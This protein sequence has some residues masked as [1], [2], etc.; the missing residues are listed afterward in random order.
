VATL[1][2]IVSRPDG[3]NEGVQ[4]TACW[5]HVQENFYELQIS[6][7]SVV[8]SQT[9]E[10]MALLQTLEALSTERMREQDCRFSKRNALLL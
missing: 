7:V 5:S 10:Q 9:L 6:D 4:P 1:P 2:I 3:A 8:T